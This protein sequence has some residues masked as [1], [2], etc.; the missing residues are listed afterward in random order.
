MAPARTYLDHNATSPIRPDVLSA[1]M[2]ALSRVGNPSSVHAEGRQARALVER[3]RAQVAGLVRARPEDVI[4]TS[5]GTEAN[6]TVL[7]PGALK[8]AT[9]RP[10][11]HLLASAVE[12]ASVL[13]GHGFPAET[14]DT[15]PVDAAGR[16]DLEGFSR[17]LDEAGNGVVLVSVQ[18]ANSETG[19]LQ[20][21]TGAAEMVR[22]ADARSTRMPSR[23]PGGCRST[24]ARS[25]STP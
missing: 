6:T 13:G 21:V 10:V 16:L 23:Q 19:I 1:V 20:P 24:W 17:A 9:G 7:R 3:A 14:F 22:S 2:E 15:I 25:G 5:G 12:H 4:F 18:L 11:T 8:T